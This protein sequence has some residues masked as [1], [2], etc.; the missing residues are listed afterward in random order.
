MCGM[1]SQAC[2]FTRLVTNIS[3][4]KGDSKVVAIKLKSVS[5]PTFSFKNLEKFTTR[6]EKKPPLQYS[7]DS[8]IVLTRYTKF[9][10]GQH[11]NVRITFFLP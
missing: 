4:N 11:G 9:D 3:V 6:L 7:K 5:L 1:K 10:T 8:Q 2:F